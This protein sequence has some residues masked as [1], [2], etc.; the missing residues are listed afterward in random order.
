MIMI[1]EMGMMK[2]MMT[3]M[4][5]EIKQSNIILR[6]MKKKVKG[7][8]IEGLH[9]IKKKLIEFMKQMRKMKMMKK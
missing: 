7:K 5:G 4:M 8:R 1:K 3:M 2:M 6:K 9:K